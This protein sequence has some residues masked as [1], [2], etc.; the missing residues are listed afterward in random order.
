LENRRREKLLTGKSLE[1]SMNNKAIDIHHHY[2]PKQL[3]EEP[4]VTARRSASTSL[5]TKAATLFRLPAANPIDC[6]QR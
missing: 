4:G 2:V 3:I 5:K 1:K 6:S